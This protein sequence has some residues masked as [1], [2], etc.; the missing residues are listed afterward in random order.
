MDVRC[1]R[2]RAHYVLEDDRVTEAGLTIRC[3]GCGYTFRVK[4]KALFVTVPV[5]SDEAAGPVTTPVPVPAVTPVPEKREWRVR[6]PNG[7]V[8]TCKELTT[9]QKWIVERKVGRDDEISL[10]GDQWKRLGDIAELASFFQLVEAADRARALPAPP[11]LTP[12]SSPPFSGT[13]SYPIAGRPPA[14]VRPQPQPAFPAPPPSAPPH[15]L[16]HQNAPPGPGG[17]VPRSPAASGAPGAAW[18][19]KPA[20]PLRAPAPE[21]A[22]AADGKPPTLVRQGQRREEPLP[23]K[24]GAGGKVALVAV[25][26]AI[27]GGGAAVYFLRPRWLGLSQGPSHRVEEAP[28]SPTPA[29]IVQGNPTPVPAAP[30]LEPP[31]PLA[32]PAAPEQ[33]KP[34][35]AAP[36]APEP[37]KPPPSPEAAVV[38]PK[39]PAS[40]GAVEQPPIPQAPEAKPGLKNEASKKEP[41]S[42]RPRVLLARARKLRDRGKPQQALDLYRQADEIEPNNPDILAGQGWCYLD[43][44]QYA[45]AVESFEAALQR[46]PNHAEALMGLAETYRYE[47]RNADAVKY[48]QRY[49]TA[50]PAGDDAVAARNAIS[51]LKE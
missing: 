4:R 16:P 14:P 44:S 1:E 11:T 12:L 29:P 26:L 35:L 15:S 23:A 3:S 21:P 10:S 42:K 19:T 28:P 46:V 7:N 43:L 41:G 30:A 49:L 33:S 45:S 6:Q 25:V 31:P 5:G 24:G 38:A 22:W 8:F 47:G 50:H 9:L 2:C 20:A 39:E 18:E 51:Q 17:P 48:Y 27:A 37:S 13:G 34:P 40:P 36:A 32:P